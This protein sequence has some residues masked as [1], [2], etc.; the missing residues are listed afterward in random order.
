MVGDRQC[1]KRNSA[2]I[3]QEKCQRGKEYKYNFFPSLFLVHF[4]FFFDQC[5][6][7]ISVV[8][9]NR[10][11]LTSHRVLFYSIYSISCF[12]QTD[13]HKYKH[14]PYCHSPSSCLE[15]IRS[16]ICLLWKKNHLY[17]CRKE[18]EHVF[19]TVQE[20]NENRKYVFYFIKYTE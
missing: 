19:R 13:G 5:E 2:I 14:L 10:T 20:I 7:K 16:I 9:L 4:S 3:I 15:F 12:G 6:R 8:A 11:Y 1:T 18:N 17:H